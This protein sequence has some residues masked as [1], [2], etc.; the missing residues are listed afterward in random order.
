[1]VEEAAAGMG[2]PEILAEPAIIFTAPTR[3]NEQSIAVTHELYQGQ[4]CLGM[5]FMQEGESSEL[6][7][8]C[9]RDLSDDYL[10]LAYH[11]AMLA[12]VL[13]CAPTGNSS[14]TIAA[15]GLGAGSLVRALDDTLHESAAV[16]AVEIDAGVVYIAAKFFGFAPSERVHVALT[17]G[18]TWLQQQQSQSLD[19]LIIDVDGASNCNDRQLAAP[20][21]SFCTAENAALMAQVCTRQGIC[22]MNV[23]HRPDSTHDQQLQKRTDLLSVY[24]SAFDRADALKFAT[25]DGVVDND[26]FVLWREPGE[27]QLYDLDTLISRARAAAP[28]RPDVASLVSVQRCRI[29][30]M[31]NS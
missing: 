11:R 3:G 1:M 21:A 17:D 16:H 9:L 8:C 13:A 29:Q 6:Q 28:Y 25:T 14:S 15:V 19:V 22:I 7:S 23:L 31:Q 10:C 20:H 4:Q 2:D 18:L 24:R 5:R 27:T 12:A 26:I 30:Y